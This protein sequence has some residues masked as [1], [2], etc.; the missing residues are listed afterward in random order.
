MFGTDYFAE[1]S[2]KDLTALLLSMLQVQIDY[3]KIIEAA[4]SRMDTLPEAV[5]EYL[6]KMFPTGV[7]GLETIDEVASKVADANR[8][9]K[10]ILETYTEKSKY[11]GEIP[12]D[13][14]TGRVERNTENIAEVSDAYPAKGAGLKKERKYPT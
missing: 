4:E 11:E 1:L 13:S 10:K 3:K 7:F 9:E 8:A 12:K 2:K 14:K 6:K 5:K